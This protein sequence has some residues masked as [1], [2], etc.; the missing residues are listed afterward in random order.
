M[1]SGDCDL[2]LSRSK[3]ETTEADV[4]S[5]SSLLLFSQ[6][7]VFAKGQVVFGDP[8]IVFFLPS[9]SPLWETQVLLFRLSPGLQV[10]FL[11]FLSCPEKGEFS[12]GDNEPDC[13][14]CEQIV[15]K[16]SIGIQ[17]QT[18]FV[19]IQSNIKLY[20]YFLLVMA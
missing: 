3:R 11:S 2:K 19:Q 10:L 20:L 5:L 12:S 6:R 8:L 9:G 17:L 7:K 1:S 4:H 16:T 15:S 14:L 18:V 13:V